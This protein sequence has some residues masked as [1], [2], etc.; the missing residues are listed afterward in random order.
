MIRYLRA[1]KLLLLRW[2]GLLPSHHI[3]R[4]MYAP[5]GFRFPANAVVYGGA[6]IRH[7]KNIQI[8]E[9]S[10]I[11]NGAI[12][13]GRAGLRIGRRVNLS[14]GVWIWT[15]QHDFRSPDFADDGA[16]R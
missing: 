9:G 3:R 14:T 8:G 2:T 16:D 13:D 4:W 7:P 12:L 11:G 6:E 5:L 1:L 10:I 15:V